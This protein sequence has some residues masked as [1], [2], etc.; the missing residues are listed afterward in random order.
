MKLNISN[1]ILAEIGKIVITH[2]LIETSLSNMIG[3]IISIRTHDQIGQIVTAELSFRQKIS[4]LRSLL[5]LCL[6]DQ[7]GAIKELDGIKGKLHEA[8]AQR[9]I[10]VH[11]N[12]FK[13]EDNEEEE[14]VVRSKTTAKEKHGLKFEWVELNL[15]EIEKITDQ[16]ADAYFK[17]S[18]LELQFQRTEGNPEPVGGDQ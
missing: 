15:K 14:V 6:T 16:V 8:D 11:S 2:N 17:I 1:E 3:A 18:M 13:S 9:N 7:H 12:W 10:V 5:V 4:L